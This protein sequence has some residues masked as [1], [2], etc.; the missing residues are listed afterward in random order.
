MSNEDRPTENQLKHIF[1]M[2]DMELDR[3]RHE[4]LSQF[5]KLWLISME[6]LLTGMGIGMVIIGGYT[7][8]NAGFSAVIN[9]LVTLV[10]V[11]FVAIVALTVFLRGVWI[12]TKVTT[13]R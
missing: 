11:G 10:H 9:S 2:Y 5:H 8:V 13:L 7:A 3:L 1:S 12:V 4:Q 6:A